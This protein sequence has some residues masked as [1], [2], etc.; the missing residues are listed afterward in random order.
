[1][2]K[3]ENIIVHC[4][5]SSWGSAKVIDEWHKARG[6]SGIGYH[7]VIGNGKITTK[8]TYDA[9]NGSIEVG[10]ILPK[11]GAHAL[12]YNSKSVGIC[13]IGKEEFTMKQFESLISLIKD[14]M[15]IY[16]IPASNVLGHKETPKSHGKTCPNFDVGKIRDYL[17]NYISE[18]P[19]QFG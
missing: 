19:I 3:I 14:L 10:R 2:N 9:L 4:S 5:D 6:W 17:V 18:I 7:F 11:S 15:M 12:G 13:L 8:N 1:M 16:D